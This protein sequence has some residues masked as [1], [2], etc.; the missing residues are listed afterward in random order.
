MP[1]PSEVCLPGGR[2][3]ILTQSNPGRSTP[4][5]DAAAVIPVDQQASLLVVADGMGGS[6]N[7]GAAAGMVVRQLA[8]KFPAPDPTASM[9]P[10]ILDGIEEANLRIQKELPGSGTTLAAVEI[11]G[12]TARPYHI[13]DSTILVIGQRGKLKL[14][15]ISHS[16]VGF[17]VEAG[18]LDEREALQHDE[19][20]LISNAIGSPDMRI[21]LG[22]PLELARY[23]TLV[24]ASDGLTDNVQV[25][26]IIQI[27]RKGPLNTALGN[28]ATL[29]RRR[30][31]VGNSQLPGKP[32]DLTVLAYR[33]S[34]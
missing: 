12:A 28:L 1:G 2:A 23:D 25:D 15:T 13:G 3:S 11:N 10:L 27:V 6:R 29:A 24:L 33:R 31:A 30:M 18:L 5:E 17:A 22:A 20:H 32:D 26:E 34:R 16:P 19:L 9:R 14:Q 21:E 4:N 8:T 7:G